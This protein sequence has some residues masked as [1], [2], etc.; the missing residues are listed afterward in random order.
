MLTFIKDYLLRLA[1]L[2][3]WRGW[4]AAYM[5]ADYALYKRLRYYE[6]RLFERSVELAD[7]ELRAH[8]LQR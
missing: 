8:K 2:D 7:D 6:M 4:V 5:A 3:G 1:V